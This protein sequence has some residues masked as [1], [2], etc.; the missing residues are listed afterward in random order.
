V[1]YKIEDIEKFAF[2][3][4]NKFKESYEEYESLMKT[5]INISN[6]KES[7]YGIITYINENLME[8]VSHL[9]SVTAELFTKA[10]M[11]LDSIK[12]RK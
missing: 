7:L 12:E 2:E 4:Q 10:Q 3:L 9:S 8:Q 5:L 1:V 6:D 11:K